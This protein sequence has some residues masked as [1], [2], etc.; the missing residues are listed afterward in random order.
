MKDF[1]QGNISK[2]SVQ[3]GGG[4]ADRFLD[5]MHG[6]DQGHAPCIADSIAQ[7]R[8][9]LQV[10]SI[11]GR[12]IVC[13]LSDSDDRPTGLEFTEGHSVIEESFDI[14]RRHSRIA[15]VVPP[16]LGSQVREFHGSG[17]IVGVGIGGV[18]IESR[19][20]P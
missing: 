9:G 8:D 11:A 6:K 17:S 3:G 13:R 5:R 10:G 2:I 19:E 20:G 16:L 14:Q 18:G 15:R 1:D 12:K 7:A 4:S